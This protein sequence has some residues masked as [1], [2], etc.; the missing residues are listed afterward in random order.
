[1]AST[2]L[3]PGYVDAKEVA[4]IGR[5]IASLDRCIQYALLAFHPQYL[6][7]DLVVTPRRQAEQRLAAARDRLH[8]CAAGRLLVN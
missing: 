8:P 2:T 7:G 5:F 3:V 4:A 1:V 6:A